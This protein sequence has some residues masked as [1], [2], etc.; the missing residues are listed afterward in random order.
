MYASHRRSEDELADVM[1]TFREYLD[2]VL[3]I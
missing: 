1:R 2:R 3:A